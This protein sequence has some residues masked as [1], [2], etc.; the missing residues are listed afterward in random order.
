MCYRCCCKKESK[1]PSSGVISSRRIARSCASV[2]SVL[3][4]N[5]VIACSVMQLPLC[6]AARRAHAL[7]CSHASQL[8]VIGGTAGAIMSCGRICVALL[9]ATASTAFFYFRTVHGEAMPAWIIAN[10]TQGFPVAAIAASAVIGYIVASTIFTALSITIDT[11]FLCVCDELESPRHRVYM[12]RR[13]A[14]MLQL[15][16]N[17]ASNAA[18]AKAP[19][20]GKGSKYV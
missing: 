11:L 18:E 19:S 2:A 15:H 4:S 3:S 20:P 7:L 14:S 16:R 17:A 13:L 1:D 5:A 8:V 9:T 10:T 6:S 12:H